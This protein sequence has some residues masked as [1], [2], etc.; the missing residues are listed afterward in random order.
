MP[1]PHRAFVQELRGAVSLKQRVL[2]SGDARLRAA[3][4]R[5]VCAL[6][7]FRSLHIAIVTKYIAIAAA[8]ARARRAQPGASTSPSAGKPPAALEAK[9]TGGSH[10]FS[11]LKSIRDTTREGM[12]SA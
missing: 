11:F 10:I 6:A 3:F 4:N 1:R 2:C 5:C 8:K 9:G 12:I 7:D